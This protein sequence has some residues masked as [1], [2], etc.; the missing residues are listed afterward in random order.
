MMRLAHI[1]LAG[2]LLTL[3]GTA[4]ALE[5]EVQEAKDEGMRLWG[6]HE[7]I[8]MQPYLEKAAEAGDV[9][10]MYYL[11]E[12]TRLLGRGLTEEAMDWYLQAAEQG[13]PYAMLRLFQGGACVA[14][15]EC[16]ENAEGWRE[17]ALAETLPKA[18]DGDTEA[19]L[20]LNYIYRAL[21][22]DG[23][24]QDWLE[25]AAE[26]GNPEA[27]T[28]LGKYILDGQSWYFLESRRLKAAEEW[29]RKAAEQGYVPAMDRLSA[30]LSN[31]ERYKD[32]WEWTV[33]SS[34]AGDLNGR[35]WLA[36]CYL[37]P[38]EA[39]RCNTEKKPVVGWAI[40]YAINEEVGG[41]SSERSMRLRRDQVTDEQCEEAKSLAEEWQ[42]KQPP[43]SNFPPRF[44]F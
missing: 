32:A 19:M 12:A 17:K 38:D 28:R 24:A 8:K 13:D 6:Q 33:K 20:A 23:E 26:Q 37:N 10:A 9:E 2:T 43:L 25:R 34:E 22:E 3:P 1:L 5:P 7:W 30:T 40:L 39:P 27:Q 42:N 15:D 44:G 18:E 14:G 35:R 16:P 21:D 11:G 29:F 4:I 36:N 31:L 41:P